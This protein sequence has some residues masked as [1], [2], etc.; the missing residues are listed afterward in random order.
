MFRRLQKRSAFTLIEL[1]VVIA[2]IAILIGLLLPAV[3]K[4]REAAARAKC[5]NN[6]KQ[7]MLAAHNFES[8]R[9]EMP[10][11]VLGQTQTVVSG[12][13]YR[14][15]QVGFLVPLMPYL[16]LD[17][18]YKLMQ[19]NMAAGYQK[20]FERTGYWVNDIP[21]NSQGFI[22]PFQEW[23]NYTS[24]LTGTQNSIWTLAQTRIGIFLCPSDNAESRTQNVRASLSTW[25]WALTIGGIYFPNNGGANLGR[26]NYLSNAGC[27]GRQVNSDASSVFYNQFQ[28]PFW[29]RS[30]L[31]LAQWTAA[32]GTAYTFGVG[33]YLGDGERGGNDWSASWM[34][35]N[36]VTAWGIMLNDPPIAQGGAWYRFGGRH[37]GIVQ[38]A[39]GDGSVRNTRKGSGYTFFANDW[40]QL[41]YASSW[42]EGYPFDPQV[43]GGN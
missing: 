35:G 26:T 20:Y 9:N 40:Y 6:L 29:S 5:Q 11:G 23:W 28:G 13:T 22:G 36:M 33:E 37:S 10:T 32:D 27:I 18:L 43:I 19:S 21:P 15:Q 24:S 7:I 17:N 42:H 3:Q 1:L 41:M 16:E 31:S 25:D 30:K 8:A 14:F 12:T 39:L 2:I 34:C 38:F 4:V